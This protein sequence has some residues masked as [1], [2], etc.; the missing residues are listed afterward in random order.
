M[1]QY[2]NDRG[3]RVLTALE[4]VAAETGA[5]MASVALAWLKAQPTIAAPIA[6]ATRVEQARQLVAALTLE[7]SAAQV[8]SLN[9]ASA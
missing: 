6:S 4:D 1:D 3:H 8:E 7:L 2:L 9:E 5:A